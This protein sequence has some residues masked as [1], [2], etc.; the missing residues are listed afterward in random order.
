MYKIVRRGR[1]GV[2]KNLILGRYESLT[3][4]FATT[5]SE[6][7]LENGDISTI[8]IDC[9][10]SCAL[11]L[12]SYLLLPLHKELSKLRRKITVKYVT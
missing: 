10:N 8:T 2:F 11:C 5:F 6:S 4:N 7:K 1:E 3:P 12:S 9:F